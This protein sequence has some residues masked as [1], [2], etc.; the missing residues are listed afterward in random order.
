MSARVCTGLADVTSGVCCA[1]VMFELPC[2]RRGPNSWERR[3]RILQLVSGLR[4]RVSTHEVR[5]ELRRAARRR[6]NHVLPCATTADRGSR[7]EEIRPFRRHAAACG[8][9][10]AG[11]VAAA[12]TAPGGSCSRHAPMVFGA[13]ASRMRRLPRIRLLVAADARRCGSADRHRSG[14]SAVR[15]CR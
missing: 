4:P 5:A 8:S 14:C 11:L 3:Y 1:T 2:L 13:T 6:T 10:S 7:G 9:R 15:Q 12:V